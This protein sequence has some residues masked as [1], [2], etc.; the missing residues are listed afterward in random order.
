[1]KT[2]VCFGDSNTWGY[3]PSD[4]GRYP[5][6]KR[7]TSILQKKLGADYFVIPEGLNGRTTAFEDSV[8]MDK[9]GYRHLQTILETHKPMDLIIIMLGTNDLKSRFNVCA[10]EIA[11]SAGKLVDYALH[12]TSGINEKHPEV[13]FIAPPIVKNSPSFGYMLEGSVKKSEDFSIH[14]KNKAQELGVPFLNASDFIV[15]SP[16]DGIHWEKEEHEKFAFAVA[17]KVKEIIS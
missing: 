10:Q 12:S 6:E 9:N 15:S 13:L 7:W 16:I 2:I 4:S 1:M 17:E 8:E 5:F 14:Y 11:W 3:S